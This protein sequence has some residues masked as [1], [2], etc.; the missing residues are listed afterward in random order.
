MKDAIFEIQATEGF[1][2]GKVAKARDSQD[3]WLTKLVEG[4]R[5]M[6]ALIPTKDSSR[7]AVADS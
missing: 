2:K 6:Q 4:N 5:K 1:P 7:V 3:D